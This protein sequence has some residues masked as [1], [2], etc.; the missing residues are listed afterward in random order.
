MSL[1]GLR[2]KICVCIHLL[3]S[4]VRCRLTSPSHVYE[5]PNTV[6]HGNVVWHPA[7]LEAMRK[8][9]DD[10]LGRSS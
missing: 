7:S 3:V 6:N 10:V 2:H 8:V 9:L 1:G 4:A 5:I